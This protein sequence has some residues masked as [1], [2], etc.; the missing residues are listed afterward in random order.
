MNQ[1]HKKYNEPQLKVL[2]NTSPSK[3]TLRH[4][5]AP[6]GIIWDSVPDTF[7]RF[8]WEIVTVTDLF[9]KAY[10][11]LANHTIHIS[12]MA[13]GA[14]LIN[15]NYALLALYDLTDLEIIAEVEGVRVTHPTPRSTKRFSLRKLLRRLL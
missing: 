4:I 10:H 8:G 15:Q 5:E 7:I 2:P 6:R 11:P 9:I 14:V 1:T 12:R 13:N 3:R